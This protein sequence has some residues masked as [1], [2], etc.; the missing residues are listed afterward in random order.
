MIILV[1]TNFVERLGYCDHAERSRDVRQWMTHWPGIVEEFAEQLRH[2]PNRTIRAIAA[3]GLGL[4]GPWARCVATDL[5]AALND[6][7]EGVRAKAWWAL[8]RLGPS[9]A[10]R[11]TKAKWRFGANRQLKVDEPFGRSEWCEVFE[12]TAKATD[13]AMSRLS[14]TAEYDKVD[15]AR[16]R[17]V[18]ALKQMALKAATVTQAAVATISQAMESDTSPNVRGQCK[19]ILEEIRVE[20]EGIDRRGPL[21]VRVSESRRGTKKRI[22]GELE[23][24]L[25]ALVDTCLEWDDPTVSERKLFQSDLLKKKRRFHGLHGR[26]S[27]TTVHNHLTML[28][29]L[30]EVR[31]LLETYGKRQF[32]RFTATAREKLEKIRP[33]I[34]ECNRFQEESAKELAKGQ[35]LRSSLTVTR[36]Q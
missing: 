34:E 19:L 2:N 24:S 23:K 35:F 8:Q 15:F 21:R 18:D 9:V 7:C 3:L 31:N 5:D 29:R 32:S 14:W 22:P 33:E 13:V 11:V 6:D 10:D 20:T 12:K 16:A 28:A 4:L 25:L 17:A 30:C 27:L 36:E 1:M 26:F